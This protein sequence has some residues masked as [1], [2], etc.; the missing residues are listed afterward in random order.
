MK[1]INR[2]FIAAFIAGM[3]PSSCISEGDCPEKESIYNFQIQIPSLAGSGSNEDKDIISNL[4]AFVFSKDGRSL[5]HITNVKINPEGIIRLTLGASE[6]GSIYFLANYPETLE[7][8]VATENELTNKST[9]P[10][11]MSPDNYF[12]TAVYNSPVTGGNSGEKLIFT[13]SVSRIDLDMGDNELL[14]I[15]SVAIANVTDRTYLFPHAGHSIPEN[16]GLTTYS[17]KFTASP[18]RSTGQIQKGIFYVYENGTNTAN[19]SVYGRFNGVKHQIDLTI[20]DINRNYLYTI[21]LNPVGQ[22]IEG[23][24]TI[25]DW[26]EGDEIQT[27]NGHT[28]T[29]LHKL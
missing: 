20:P 26:Q 21:I 3:L 9:S 25:Q 24:I 18:G 7:N 2:L 14:E 28:T 5:Q 23:I 13:R 6:I 27:G 19:V 22:T 29:I 11:V 1:K 4:D 15:D 16:A 10:K 12:L 17:K 8:E